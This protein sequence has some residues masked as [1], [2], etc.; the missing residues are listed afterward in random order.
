MN[1]FEAMRLL[2]RVKEGVPI[3]LRLITEALIL[4]GDLDDQ[5]M[6]QWYTVE[7]TSLMQETELF[8]RKPKQGKYTELG[9]P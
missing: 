9:N 8:W 5:G 1:Y 4:T 7:K 3:P 2:D 6:Y